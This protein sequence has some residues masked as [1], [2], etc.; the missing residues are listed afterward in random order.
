MFFFFGGSP[1]GRGLVPIHDYIS[2]QGWAAKTK[3]RVKSSTLVAK[4]SKAESQKLVRLLLNYKGNGKLV[5]L[6][7]ICTYLFESN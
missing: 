6:R 4:A 1:W 5:S 3:L 2:D 7:F